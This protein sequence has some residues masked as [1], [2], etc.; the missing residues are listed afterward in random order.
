MELLIKQQTD[1]LLA[2]QLIRPSHCEEAEQLANAIHT[3]YGILI[4]LKTAN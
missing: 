2:L 4:R 1:L 3:A